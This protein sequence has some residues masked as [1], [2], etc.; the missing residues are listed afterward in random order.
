[1]NKKILPGLKIT[2][3][4][5]FIAAVV[6]GIIF[7]IFPTQY[8]NLSG[9]PMPDPLPYR[10]VGAFL[11]SLGIS[12]WLAYQAAFYEQVRILVVLEIVGTGLSSL[13]L[14]WNLVSEAMPPAAWLNTFVMGG[15]FM[16]FLGFYIKSEAEVPQRS[17]ARD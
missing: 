15:F 13:M 1:M 17:M 8:A 3:L 12:S 7:F 4:I 11:L 14:L 5:H 9:L 16:V 10:I 6:F 2:F